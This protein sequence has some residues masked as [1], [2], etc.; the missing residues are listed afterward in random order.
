VPSDR[1]PVDSPN[2]LQ[3]AP[4]VRPPV[5]FRVLGALVLR[6]P[7]GREISSTVAQPKRLAL[8]LHLAL[9]GPTGSTRAIEFL[10]RDSLLA[11]FWPDL[12]Q[13]H[14][15][16]AL[17]KALQFLR[18]TLGEGAIVTRGEEE[19]GLDRGVVWCDAV[20]F[21]EAVDQRRPQ[22]ALALYQGELA[23]GLYIARAAGVEEWLERERARLRGLAARA[24]RGLCEECETASR[25]TLAI[26]WAR[27]A[28]ALAPD[29]ERAWRGLIGLL[30]RSGDR[31]GA[32]KAHHEL[33][34]QL[35]TEYEI[36]PSLETQQLV[37]DIRRRVLLEQ[38]APGDEASTPVLPSTRGD[39]SVAVSRRPAASPDLTTDHPGDASVAAEPIVADRYLIEREVTRPGGMARV[40]VARDRKHDRLVAL[41]VLAAEPVIGMGRE[42]FLRE[43][44]ITARLNHPRIL[45][46]H[47][48]GEF[49]G[50]PYYVTPFIDGETLRDR[51][52]RE[53][54]LPV[55][56]A[57]G[58][59]C[60][61]AAALE[62]AHRQGV[63]H[64]D[65]K[66]E[67][68]LLRAGEVLVADFGIAHAVWVAAGAEPTGDRLTAAGI[69]LGTPAYMS[70]E[71]AA[72]DRGPDGRSDIY[73]LAAV[74]YEMLVG[75][76]P[77]TGPDIR[78]VLAR[79]LTDPVRPVRATRESVPSDLDAVLQ[80][81]LAKLPADRFQTA[82]EFASA[83]RDAL[84]SP[85][86]QDRRIGPRRRLSWLRIRGRP[87]MVSVGKLTL[88][89][90]GAVIATSSWLKHHPGD[91]AG[92]QSVRRWNIVLP[93]SAPLA[94]LGAAPFGL[95]RASLTISPDGSRLVYVAQ[96]GAGTQL[97]LRA[98]DQLDAVPLP[99][100]EG[101][102]QPFFSPDG[103]WIGFFAGRELK[104]VA[105]VGGPAVT[106][107]LVREPLGGVWASDERILVADFQGYR[108]SWIPSAGGAAQP[109]TRWTG[110]RLVHPD[111]VPTGRSTTEWVLTGSNAG[112]LYLGSLITGELFVLTRDGAVH[113]EQLDPSKAFFGT[114]PRYLRSGHIAYF[115]SS[116]VL[117]TFPFD[118]VR[119]RVLGPPKPALQGVRLEAPEGGSQL[120][121][122]E[123]GTLV[124]APGDNARLS[125]L[126]WVDHTTGRVDTLQFPRA[127]YGPFALSPDGRRLVARIIPASGP[128][129]IW[130]LGLEDG[131]RTHVP[132]AGMP[133]VTLRW[134]PDGDGVLFAEYAAS[135]R[136]QDGVLVHQWLSQYGR[137]DTI[138]RGVIHFDASRSGNLLAVAA[139]PAP[140]LRMESLDRSAEPVQIP[141]GPVA[142]PRFSPDARWIAYTD[143]SPEEVEVKVVRITPPG[144]PHTLSVN[145]GEE[146]TWTPDGRTVVYRNGE[147]WLAVTISASG[148]LRTSRPH[149]VF[150]GPYL[151][152]PGMSHDIS[153]DGRRQLV[154]LGSPELATRRL[155][156]VTNWFAELRH[157]AVSQ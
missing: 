62:Y 71:Q 44:R 42:R 86:G 11:L 101:A 126:A 33:V 76:P 145:G 66:P 74:L 84:S 36:E 39:T 97:Y 52:D 3:A 104:K 53:R 65:M 38:S 18:R 150:Q 68:I 4:A 34:T 95:G 41:K 109:A 82:A 75:E 24:A 77:H 20:A 63:I 13:S 91:G 70:P 73:S 83:L 45:P 156:V 117:M 148:D 72:G 124:Y 5:E 114:N 112:L 144:I 48:S 32:L 125:V 141:T 47:D 85:A 105:V 12:D 19:V 118:A 93:D 79:V 78:A 157:G 69:T 154:L 137:R 152:V 56:V 136:P 8:L 64:R 122:S 15:R 115:T 132:V 26:D 111:L 80:K 107:A 55:E 35:A 103:R 147:Q 81:A 10:R 96:R 138:A 142:F 143:W 106:L 102:Y 1:S 87:L 58:T 92:S 113:P 49:A 130:V 30:D 23:P 28:V 149:L 6:D 90:A 131:E 89:T 120:T 40:F 17:R 127:G 43:I 88:L 46:L 2:P 21:L 129:E 151:Q 110:P 29:D 135:G 60:Q 59:T 61:V 146:P 153:S 108:S 67:N 134:W 57:V 25:L 50:L 31:A 139:F 27:R 116:G 98:L 37:A 123:D 121:V 14:A 100:T 7:A 99:G 54:V 9:A 94:F 140:G 51:L 16:G 22:D 119:R 155:V 133:G 128:A